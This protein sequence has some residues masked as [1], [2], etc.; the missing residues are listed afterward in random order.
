MYKLLSI[1]KL[2]ICFY[3]MQC[4]HRLEGRTFLLSTLSSLAACILCCVEVRY[5]SINN[6]SFFV[7]I[8]T[9]QLVW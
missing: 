4:R 1:S 5:V 8:L 3:P 2:K 6:I 9:E 7:F